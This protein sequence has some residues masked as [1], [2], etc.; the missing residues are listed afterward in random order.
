MR[1]RKLGNIEIL[2]SVDLPTRSLTI[3]LN[4][5]DTKFLRERLRQAEFLD[6]GATM[7]LWNLK[8]EM[9]EVLSG[10][11]KE[12]MFR[13]ATTDLTS[14]VQSN[15]KGYTGQW[16]S[17]EVFMPYDQAIGNLERFIIRR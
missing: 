4:Q 3:V 15:L 14:Q 12:I 5:Q 9:N 2:D 7:L 6:A 8:T 17:V 11:G 13:C 1:P 16:S 10:Q